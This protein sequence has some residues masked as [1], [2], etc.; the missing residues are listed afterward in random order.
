MWDEFKEELRPMRRKE[1]SDDYRYFPEPDLVEVRIS[2]DFIKDVSALLPELPAKRR[3]RY[4][5]ELKLGS[6]AV[7]VL[8]SDRALGDYFEQLCSLGVN[9]ETAAKWVQGDVQRALNE[10][11]W[12]IQQFPMRPASL[13]ALI[14][15]VTDNTV[16]LSKA[17][18]IFRTMLSTG[19]S[20]QEII[21]SEGAAQIGNKDE[22]RVI[23]EQVVRDHPG[24][25]ARYQA[26]RTNLFGFFVGEI[27]KRTSGRANP[28][29]ANDILQDILRTTTQP[30][31]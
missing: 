6:E 7:N 19:R 27:M 8:V 1:G 10:N 25:V 30:N 20:A 24:E 15:A 16:S 21:A 28:K 23:V 22:L 14:V 4:A 29:L 11:G 31:S 26:G 2:E 5:E 12:S 17:K 9:A 3:Q 18:Q 13:S